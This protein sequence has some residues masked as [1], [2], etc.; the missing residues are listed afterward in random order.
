M[1]PYLEPFIPGVSYSTLPTS[2]LLELV[3]Q[4]VYLGTISLCLSLY[5]YIV[6]IYV[7]IYI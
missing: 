2:N 4:N 3:T 6:H 5:I 1:G 7:Y